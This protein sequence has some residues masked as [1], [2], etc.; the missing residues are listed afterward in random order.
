MD[1]NCDFGKCDGIR[2]GQPPTGPI[3]LYLLLLVSL[4]VPFLLILCQHWPMSPKRKMWRPWCVTTETVLW[5]TLLF[6]PWLPWQTV[7]GKSSS[8]CE[9]TIEHLWRRPLERQ[10]IVCSD[11]TM[12]IDVNYLF[13][14]RPTNGPLPWILWWNLMVSLYLSQPNHPEFLTNKHHERINTYCFRQLSLVITCTSII[15][16]WNNGIIKINS[17]YNSILNK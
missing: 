8:I 4:E 3:Y 9:A 17:V 11:H 10:W 2:S 14:N 6:L 16:Y 7:F 5:N 12:A 13:P 1:Y 15:H